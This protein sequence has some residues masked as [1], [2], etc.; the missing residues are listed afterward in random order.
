MS[1]E[2]SSAGARSAQQLQLRSAGRIANAADQGS[3]V[4][5]VEAAVNQAASQNSFNANVAALKVQDE[6]M[7]TL[8][9]VMA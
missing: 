6:M 7:G 5:V 8:L 2:V 3:N 4:N 1:I 9:D